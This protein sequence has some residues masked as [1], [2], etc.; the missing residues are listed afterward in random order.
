MS[1]ILAVS[2]QPGELRAAWLTDGRLTGLTLRCEH[3]PAYADRVYLGRVASLDAALGAAFVEIGLARP[4]FLPLAEAPKGLSQG[5]AVAVRV[6]REP[7]ADPREAKGARLSAWRGGLPGPLAAVAARAEPPALLH[8]PGDPLA[9]LQSA[10]ELPEEIVID[11]EAS[12]ARARQALA[13]RPEGL[14]RL[15]LDL[16]PEPLFERLGIEAEIEAL[17]EPEVALP[18]GGGLLIEPGRTLTAVDVNAGRHG[19]GGAAGQALAVDL[20]AA[21]VLARQIRLR[22][23]SGLL[24]VDFLALREPAARRRVAEVL[25]EGLRGDPNPARIQ[26]PRPSGL[27]EMTRRRAGPPLHE[28]LAEPCGRCA[29]GWVPSAPSLAFQ[30]LRRLRP[31][32]AGRPLRRLG[33]VAAP[34]V[35]AALEGP[36]A[37][38]RAAL[39]ARLG[40]TLALESDPGE[41]GYRIVLE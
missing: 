13:A 8:D 19:A 39:E 35:A 28:I 27:L 5:E 40:R 23:L 33:L 10:P 32:A 41:T 9:A 22:N 7:P 12:H 20:E 17:L 38:A 4:G 25:R 34:A 6:K 26:T 3:A 31:R 29:A 30:A 1:R 18:S 11:D 2:A 15:R 37:A 16:E 14:E 24:V 36:C 21:A